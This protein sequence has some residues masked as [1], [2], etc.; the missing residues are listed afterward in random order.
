MQLFQKIQKE[1]RGLKKN[2]AFAQILPAT[3]TE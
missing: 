3:A 1:G 2:A